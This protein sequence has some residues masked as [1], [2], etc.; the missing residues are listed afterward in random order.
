MTR[1][2][3]L[4]HLVAILAAFT[5]LHAADEAPPQNPALR[6]FAN[7]LRMLVL[8]H[9]PEASS[10]LLGD[11][12]HFE[13]NTRPFIVH[14]A[15]KTGEWQDP[16]EERGPKLGGIQGS[17]VLQKGRYAGAAAVPQTFDK[18]YF[19]ILMLAPYPQEKDVHLVVHL[20]YPRNVKP[21]FLEQFTALVNDFGK[22]LN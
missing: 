7:E 3:F 5:P 15:T 18:R 9:Y 12:V 16:W 20:A 19:K 13:Y 22:H 2:T 4:L 8:R 17:L 1:S 14:E 6:R 10:H 21:E 11:K